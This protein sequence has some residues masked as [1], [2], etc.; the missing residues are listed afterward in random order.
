M[1]LALLLLACAR[2]P[3]PS[4][5]DDAVR[6][7][8]ALRGV[9]PS[10]DELDA[11]TRGEASL[12]ELAR[13]WVVD[14]RFGAVV[15]DLHAEQLLLRIDTQP[16]PPPMGP[17]AG[18]GEGTLTRS[19]DEE[20]LRLIEKV[21]TDGRPY[22]EILTTPTTMADAN[23]AAVWGL[24]WDPAGPEWQEVAWEDGRPAAGLLATNGFWQR[25]QS[26][27]QNR[28]RTRAAKVLSALVCQSLE[29]GT[30]ALG[31]PESLQ[32]AVSADPAC[33]TCHD[34]IDPIAAAFAGAR[35]YVTEAEVRTAERSGCPAPLAGDC[36]PVVMWDD[37]AAATDGDR[38]GLPAPGWK[39]EPVDGLA[40][41]GRA[42]ATDPGFE[43][44]TARRFRAWFAQEPWEAV[45]ASTAAT[46]A[47]DLRSADGD[48]RELALAVVLDPG[49]L[50]L[51]RLWVRPEHASALVEQLTGFTWDL[52]PDG[53]YGAVEVGRTDEFG[54]RALMGGVDGWN[55]TRPDAAPSPTRELSWRWLASDAAT[56]A[57]DSG[58]EPILTEEGAVREALRDLHRRWLAEEADED[59]LDADLALFGAA[60]DRGDARHAWIVVLTALLLDD[61]VVGY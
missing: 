2:D 21:V 39:N 12:E 55:S 57:V 54:L 41:L 61:R 32:D 58:R 11:L 60:L 6:V 46:L 1:L 36:Y 37:G 40:G 10:S 35:K 56:Y 52:R 5:I 18:I 4:A 13:R 47:D 19:L 59:A 42:L 20:P 15:R 7:S 31:A 16:H 26:S 53:G 48:A 17:L 30:I 9:H 22:G 28:H 51:P 43:V 50:A 8:V 38:W 25:F 34:V 33:T 29:S 44:C 49:F 45:E 14:P 3:D 24:P 27:E 23:V